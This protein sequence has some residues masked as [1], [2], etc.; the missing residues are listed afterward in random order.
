MSAIA[1]FFAEAQ[2]LPGQLAQ[3][4]QAVPESAWLIMWGAS[5]LLLAARTRRVPAKVRLSRL[6]RTRDAVPSGQR[7][8]EATS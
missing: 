8:L 6:E 4:I 2:I 7:G 1:G 3:A 5:L